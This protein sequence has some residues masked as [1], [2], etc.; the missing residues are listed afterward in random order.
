MQPNP[1][2][3][4]QMQQMQPNPM[5]Q[6]AYSSPQQYPPQQ[7]YYQQNVYNAPPPPQPQLVGFT[8]TTV[9]VPG[10]G[11]DFCRI[12]QRNTTTRYEYVSGAT[13]FI[14]CFIVWFFT[15][16]LCFIPFCI[17]SCKD[18][19]LVCTVCNTIK[20]RVPASF[21]WSQKTFLFIHTY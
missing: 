2:N 8:Q 3:Q 15:G 4:G 13:T 7:P 12:C 10:G 18:R 1:M 19:R 5:N 20:G 16:I 9:V 11:G 21:I 6:N 17:D 14:W